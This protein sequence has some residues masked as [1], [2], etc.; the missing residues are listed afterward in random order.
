MLFL[1]PATLLYILLFTNINIFA[2]EIEYKK[3]SIRTGI[4][5]GINEGDREIGDGFVYSVGWQKS[6][7]KKNKLRINPYVAFGGFFPF[8]ITDTRDQFY[9]ISNLGLYVHYDLIRYKAVSIVTTGGCFINFS[10]GL[11]GTGGWPDENNVGSEYFFAFYYGGNGSIGLRINPPKSKLA[12]EIRPLNMHF[13]NNGFIL[14]YFMI[15]L[16][17][18]LIK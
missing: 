3:G 5:V 7:G 6:Y 2:Q 1:K 14:A 16:D 17:F 4:G 8:A 18:K 10:R 11:L 9:K 13:G 12:Y 15:G